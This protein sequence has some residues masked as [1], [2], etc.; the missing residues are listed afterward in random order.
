ITGGTGLDNLFGGADSDTFIW[1]TGD[2]SDVIEG[3]TG[4]DIVSTT[5]TAGAD[6]LTVGASGTR[7][8]LGDGTDTLSVAG[9]ER[10][11]VNAGGGTDVGDTVTINDLSGTEVQLV[12]LSVGTGDD[13]V[14]IHGTSGADRV[15]MQDVA[16]TV[17][18]T[19]LSATI[20]VL[21]TDA[22]ADRVTFDGDG[23]DDHLEVT[24]NAATVTI[25][26][27][28]G[29]INGITAATIG[30]TDTEAIHVVDGGTTTNLTIS[31]STSYTHTPGANSGEGTITANSLN[32][33]YTGLASSETIMLSGAGG[34][35]T[36][37]AYGTSGDDA[38][39]I[40]AASVAIDGR[41]TLNLSDTIET[42][43]IES[44]DGVDSHD[45]TPNAGNV[46]NIHAGGASSSD[47]LTFNGQGAAVVLDL[48][49]GSITESL[50]GA[51][52]YTGVEQLTVDHA[53]GTLDIDG[54]AGPDTFVATPLAADSVRVQTNGLAPVVTT[55]GSAV[56]TI[57]DNA[58]GS[59]TLTVRGTNAGETITIDSTDVNI[60]SLKAVAYDTTNIESLIVE[61]SAGADTFIVTPDANTPVIFLD[62]GDPIGTGDS[63]TL[64]ATATA[65]FM[66]GPQS[67][68]GQFIIDSHE[69]ISF[70][71]I[72]AVTVDGPNSGSTL[73][74]T[75]MGTGD[76][77]QFTAVGQGT[78]DVDLQ[79]NNGLVVSYTDIASITLQGKAGDDDF[80]LD[81]N[82]LSA[83][84][85][86][87]D[88]GDPSTDADSVTVTGTSGVDTAN[89]TP[90][91][92]DG[93]SLTIA[94]LDG[95]GTGNTNLITLQ[96]VERLIYDGEDENETLTVTSAT[97]AARTLT[98]R[99]GTSIDS[100][101]VQVGNWL[102][103][104]YVSLGSTG[105]LTLLDGDADPGDD[106]LVYEGT[107]GDDAFSVSGLGVVQRTGHVSVNAADLGALTLQLLT[108]NDSVSIAASGLFAGGINVQGGDSD[109]TSDSVTLT[110]RDNTADDNL[111]VSLSAGTVTGLVGGTIT[112]TGVEDLTVNANGAMMKDEIDV[113]GLG[114]STSLSRVTINGNANAADT[115]DIIGTAN[116]DTLIYTATTATSG[117]F[118]AAGVTTVVSYAGF[119]GMLTADG[120]SGAA[121]VLQIVGGA[122]IDTVTSA[123]ATSVTLLDTLTF[124]NID[125]LDITTFG[126]NDSVTLSHA[127]AIPVIVDGGDDDDTINVSGV[128]STTTLYGGLGNDT[129]TGSAQADL[130]YGGSGNDVI[131]AGAGADTVYGEAGDDT[132]TGGTGLDNL[133]GGADSDTFIW[134][135][136]D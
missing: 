113:T 53:A 130:I 91:S 79:V 55:T 127:I 81:V 129:L 105:S 72:E 99:E 38:F 4:A 36:L 70:D 19:G 106:R 11:N 90:T 56:L 80:D 21:Q 63:I 93:G 78:N 26:T 60:G 61:G 125:R 77:D 39:T 82:S 104:E 122:G 65:V 37:T 95:Q 102:A 47:S 16:G 86:T 133:F 136:G 97:G 66:P 12:N 45:V 28:T 64:N 89:F 48:G 58:G 54:T 29:S 31:G 6:T 100:G 116:N 85:I 25:D 75:V 87:I 101:S 20:N 24:S 88:G 7:V 43:T 117:V 110:G 108:G 30:Y 62:G 41:A 121:D 128:A 111:V 135:T 132:I 112:L 73:A 49:A 57:R 103:V 9:V 33:T 8:T 109:P 44:L 68:E 51:V 34:S 107:S 74:I 35:D 5:H 115:L 23:S 27:A 119:G 71:H 17:A 32:V 40:S 98:H 1:T 46:F 67:D 50:L 59:D 76:D 96:N 84:A 134:T 94:G 123:S 120:F 15:S 92:V 18:V 42:I 14:T 126:G 52:N 118:T 114:G 3:E 13:A 2:G 131:S 69:P 124:A 83:V 22:T 10:L